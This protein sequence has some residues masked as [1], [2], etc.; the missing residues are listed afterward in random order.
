M[1]WV[2]SVCEA[3]LSKTV[4]EQ[5]LQF[6]FFLMNRRP[7]RSPLFPYTTLFRSPE[8]EIQASVRAVG[9]A[10]QGC[11]SPTESAEGRSARDISRTPSNFGGDGHG[12]AARTG[13]NGYARR[14]DRKSTRLN[15]SH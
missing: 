4:A 1:T 5:D 11:A 14:T 12:V 13:R 7:P 10:G 15:S 9:A 2:E 3:R 8:R 6:F